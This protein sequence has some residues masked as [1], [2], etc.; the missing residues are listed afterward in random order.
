M[1]SLQ[2]L[3]AKK[4][5]RAMKRLETKLLWKIRKVMLENLEWQILEI[6]SWT[7]VNFQ[8]YN[9]RA[10]VTAIEPSIHMIHKAEPKIDDKDIT[11]LE[12]T[13][14]EAIDENL[15]SETWYDHVVCTLVLCSVPDYQAMID[16]LIILLKPGWTMIILEHIKSKNS[17]IWF[18]QTLF[19]PIQNC[20]ADG[21]YLDRETDMYLKSWNLKLIEEEYFGLANLFYKAEYQSRS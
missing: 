18:F 1:F 12:K 3:F 14:E 15:L 16:E 13:I 21:C 17:V 7:W 2:K 8:Y 10:S 5:D 11:M 20:I 6:G 9:S 19:N 4:Y